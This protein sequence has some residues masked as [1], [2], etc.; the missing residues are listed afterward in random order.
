M[1][2]PKG[3]LYLMLIGIIVLF[4]SCTTIDPLTDLAVQSYNL[5][6]A[7][8]Q[9]SNS[10][11]AEKAFLYA[12]QEYPAYTEA[13]YSLALLYV[14]TEDYLDSAEIVS[15]FIGDNQEDKQWRLLEAHLLY[16]LGKTNEA[17]NSYDLILESWP[18]DEQRLEVAKIAL[19][20]GQY[21]VAQSHLL[22]LFESGS[23]SGELLFLLGQFEELTGGDKSLEWY[24]IAVLEDPGYLPSLQKLLDS[25]EGVEV[26]T[27]EYLELFNILEEGNTNTSGQ[28]PL[29]IELG[30]RA[31]LMGSEDG[32]SYLSE[33]IELGYDD[34]DHLL[35]IYDSLEGELSE[36][37]LILLSEKG[38]IRVIEKS[39]PP[40]EEDHANE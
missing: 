22:A 8:M 15:H 2:R 32:L 36:S 28:I 33:A 21:D 16:K 17:L 20:I 6:I 39:P 29:L 14:D 31:L 11:E 30:E 5:G 3:Y 19:N 34:I 10:S 24:K 37:L 35:G 25:F 7:N 1:D 38:L 18:D 13:A 40:F 9:I 12:L 26:G 23:L 27:P 4:S